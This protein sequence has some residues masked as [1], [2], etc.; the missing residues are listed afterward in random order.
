M[1]NLLKA[2]LK[3][4]TIPSGALFVI[5]LIAWPIVIDILR[6]FQGKDRL[7]FN[8]VPKLNE[9][10]RQLC[11]D[12][13]NSAMSPRLTP[14]DFAGITFGLSSFGWLIV[15]LVNHWLSRRIRDKKIS[16][17]NRKKN[18]DHYYW[19]FIGHI[20]YQLALLVVIM[21]LFCCYQK[22][23]YPAEYRCFS[24]NT[25]LTVF[26]QVAVNFTC[27]DIRYNEKSKVNIVI[28][29]V[30]SLSIVLSL[31]AIIQLK[32]QGKE[33]ILEHLLRN[34][35]EDEGEENASL[36]E[37]LCYHLYIRI[38]QVLSDSYSLKNFLGTGTWQI[39]QPEI[40]S[41]SMMYSFL[42]DLPIFVY[43]S[44]VFKC[45]RKEIR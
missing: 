44:G 12:K 22:L 28:I 3:S 7:Q 8:C 33:K 10:T 27:N 37:L 18:V 32:L 39:N 1:D 40:F 35:E 6:D 23:E 17:A 24:A 43:Y 15:T 41:W 38:L 34:L 5:S 16:K 13:Y 31:A 45:F 20:C 2:T 42:V 11:Y 29:V 25:T 14:L 21:V 19:V 26:N 36:G 4:Q 30:F 9:V